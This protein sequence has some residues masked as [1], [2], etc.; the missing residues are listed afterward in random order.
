[1]KKAVCCIVKNEERDIAEWIAFH[2]CMGFD[3]IIL[4]DN[5]SNDKTFSIACEF[6][7]KNNIEII[8][9]DNVN[10]TYQID[11]YMDCIEKFGEVFDWIL[12]IDSDEFYFE[13]HFHSVDNRLAFLGNFGDDVSQICLNWAT[14]GSSGYKN[15]PN[16]LTIESFIYLSEP[17]QGIN[18]HVKSFV[19]PSHVVDRGNPHYFQVT[20]RTVDTDGHD[21]QWEVPGLAAME[22]NYTVARVNHYWIKSEAHWEQKISRGYHDIPDRKIGEFRNFDATCTWRD[23]SAVRYV[24]EVLAALRS[25]GIVR[26]PVV[27]G[28]VIRRLWRGQDPFEGFPAERYEMDTQGWGSV[29]PFLTDTIGEIRPRIVAEMGVWKGGS[30]LTMASTLKSLDLDAVVIAVDT[31]LGS[32][33]HWENDMWFEHLKFERGYPTLM[34]TFMTNVIKSELQDFVVP[35]PLD[36]LNAVHVLRAFGIALDLVHIDGSHAYE[37]VSADIRAWW[38][39]LRPGGVLIGDDYDTGGSWPDV[40]RAYDDFFAAQGLVPFEYGGNKCR[41]RKPQASG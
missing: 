24:P 32:W 6:Q 5:M 7:K 39:L 9:W 35:L 2:F 18:R 37:A 1:M 36:S 21:V 3:C 10:P 33:D 31:W 19:R 8:E 34:R 28:D 23:E 16:G 25:V 29:H 17:S 20:N 30:T 4:Y 41:I 40:R 26:P 15:F 11:A 13:K 27:R 38:S 22:P 12:F 14:F